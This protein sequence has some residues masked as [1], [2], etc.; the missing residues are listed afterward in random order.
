ML[1]LDR[2]LSKELE[3][4]LVERYRYH[5][6]TRGIGLAESYRLATGDLGEHL[7]SSLTRFAAGINADQDNDVAVSGRVDYIQSIVQGVDVR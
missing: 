6:Y 3:L 4:Y 2:S 5:R 7:S 1:P